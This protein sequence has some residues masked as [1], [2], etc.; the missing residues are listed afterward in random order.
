MNRTSMLAMMAVL[1]LTSACATGPVRVRTLPP[2]TPAA[3]IEAAKQRQVA[4]QAILAEEA[5][6]AQAAKEAPTTGTTDAPV[7][8]PVKPSDAPSMQTYD[9]YERFNRA[10]YRFNARFDEHV[11]LPVANGYRRLPR[12]VQSGVHNFFGNLSDISNTVNFGLQGRGRHSLRALGRFAINSTVGIGGLFD[13]ARYVKLPKAN[14]GFAATLSRWGMRPGP[15]LV[16]PI[17]GPSTV[18]GGAGYAGD[19][20]FNWVADPGGFYRGSSNA[21]AFGATSS[22]DTRANTSFS[23]YGTG[24]PFEYEMVR[25]L[26]VRKLLIEDE[27]LH[28]D[29]PEA[30]RVPG[31]VAGQ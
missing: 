7:T 23:Y 22:V 1:A 8:P 4:L 30:I 20:G 9:P 2:E 16:L 31:A 21:W 12:P 13:V 11:F 14:T 5:R 6:L 27:G 10:M 17:L 25:F 24:S 26:F 28:A 15:Y 19:F 3:N 18:R 29:N